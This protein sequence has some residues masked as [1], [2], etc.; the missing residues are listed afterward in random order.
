VK[1]MRVLSATKQDIFRIS[2]LNMALLF[3]GKQHDFANAPAQRGKRMVVRKS[4][5]CA[6]Q[7]VA[8]GF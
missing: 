2:S 5:K 6:K 3:D 7:N 8:Q 4:N 1:S